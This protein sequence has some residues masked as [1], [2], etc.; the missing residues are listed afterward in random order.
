MI[1]TLALASALIF[2]HHSATPEPPPD[3]SREVYKNVAL[4]SVD[5]AL[6]HGSSDAPS[7]IERLDISFKSLGRGIGDLQQEYR[8]A[9]S[10]ALRRLETAARSAAAGE[11]GD[12]ACRALIEAA[13]AL[14]EADRHFSRQSLALDDQLHEETLSFDAIVDVMKMKHDEATKAIRSIR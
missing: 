1:P 4:A 12:G 7:A 13:R 2:A 10:P 3:S 11:G 5:Q 6:G 9:L 8:S 14:V